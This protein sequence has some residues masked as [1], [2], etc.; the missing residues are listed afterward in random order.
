MIPDSFLSSSLSILVSLEKAVLGTKSTDL[1][2]S[3]L[4]EF[5]EFSG[6]LSFFL[7]FYFYFLDLDLGPELDNHLF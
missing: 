4:L 1:V 6:F 3:G 5:L 7:F 2:F